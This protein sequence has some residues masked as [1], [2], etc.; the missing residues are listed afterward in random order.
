MAEEHDPDAP[1]DIPLGEESTAARVMRDKIV[2]EMVPGKWCR[3]LT[4]DPEARAFLVIKTGELYL[5]EAADTGATYMLTAAQ[6]RRQA[7][8]VPSS[9]IQ[10]AARNYE[11]TV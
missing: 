5:L 8:R 9:W 1:R 10:N 2:E 6:F 7:C 4:C 11:R 3:L